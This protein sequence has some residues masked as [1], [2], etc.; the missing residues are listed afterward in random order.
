MLKTL[1]KLYI[2]LKYF[3]GTPKNSYI[4]TVTKKKNSFYLFIYLFYSAECLGT[5][6]QS[7][8]TWLPASLGCESVVT[9]YTNEVRQKC[10]Y[11]HKSDNGYK[12]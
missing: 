12:K 5:L 10:A 8:M 11:L 1:G 9:E 6:E 3:L 7:S 4:L 2:F